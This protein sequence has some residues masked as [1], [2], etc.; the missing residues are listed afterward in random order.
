MSWVLVTV[1]CLVWSHG[2]C[3]REMR[4]ERP[5]QSYDDCKHHFIQTVDRYYTQDCV[6]RISP[7][8]NYQ[9][10]QQPR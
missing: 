7:R 10:V 9:I 6:R 3:V 2:T 1:A 4:H 5:M 8:E